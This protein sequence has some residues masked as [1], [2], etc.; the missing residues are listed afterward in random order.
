MR[1]SE[2]LHHKGRVVHRART[3]ETVAEAVA[4]L[5][6]HNVGA[7]LVY[8]GWGRY[9]GIISERDVVRALDRFGE[10]AAEMMVADLMSPDLITCHPEDRVNRAIALM[11][12]HRIR[13]LPVEDGGSIVGIVSIGDLVRSLIHD[14]EL[15]VEVLRDMAQVH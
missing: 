6:Q 14:K 13:H 10:T 15:E 1:I 5:A 9:V 2:I 8:D 12:A 4:R 7:L 11:T 3:S